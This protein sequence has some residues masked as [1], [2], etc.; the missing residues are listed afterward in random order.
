MKLL[1]AFHRGAQELVAEAQKEDAGGAG[2]RPEK[3]NF[4][5]GF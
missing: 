4:A 2:V 1:V 5:T 3:H